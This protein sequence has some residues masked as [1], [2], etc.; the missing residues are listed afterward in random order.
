[1]PSAAQTKITETNYFDVSIFLV[2]WFECFATNKGALP[3]SS[4]RF[5]SSKLTIK[6]FDIC[7]ITFKFTQQPIHYVIFL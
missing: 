1:M 6:D 7:F 4:E 2:G 5:V 3:G